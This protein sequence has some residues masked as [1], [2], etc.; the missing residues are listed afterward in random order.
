M[1]TDDLAYDMAEWRPISWQWST[2]GGNMFTIGLML[3]FVDGKVTELFALYG[4]GVMLGKYS[5]VEK[6]KE[7]VSQICAERQT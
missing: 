1:T 3:D 6:A 2:P 5:T 7:K 4:N